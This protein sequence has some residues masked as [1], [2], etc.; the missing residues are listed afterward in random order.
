MAKDDTSEQNNDQ[1]K[2]IIKVEHLDDTD[3]DRGVGEL[4]VRLP[5]ELIEQL[6][7]EI[8]DEVEW[9]ETEIC[10][11]WGEAKGFTLSNRSKQLRDADRRGKKQHQLTWSD[12]MKSQI[13]F[14]D[15]EINWDEMYPPGI[16]GHPEMYPPASDKK[17]HDPIVATYWFCW[18]LSREYLTPTMLYRYLIK[19]PWQRFSRGFD[20]RATWSLDHTIAKFAIPRLEHLKKTTHG[21]P[22]V[23]G[24]N[25]PEE[26][27]ECI[28]KMIWSFQYTLS[29]YDLYDNSI[30]DW[31]CKESREYHVKKRG[32]QNKRDF[33]RFRAGMRLFAKFYP[34]LWD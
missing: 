24:A 16:P 29:E 33:V 1:K 14:E 23:K 28:D 7:W 8:G 5:D 9:E 11:E 30:C 2:W 10:E 13:N 15:A 31:S 19:W 4:C 25:T 3:P 21:Y 22:G 34:N 6:G 17:W 20:D 18:R 12:G 27:I 32:K 26:W